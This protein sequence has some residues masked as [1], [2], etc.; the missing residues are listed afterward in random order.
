VNEKIE[1]RIEPGG[2]GVAAHAH[3][4][5]WATFEVVTGTLGARVGGRRT[6]L[7]PGQMLG[8]APHVSHSWWN[9]GDDELVVRCEIGSAI[10]PAS[11]ARV[12]E[13]HAFEPL[14]LQAA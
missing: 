12:V 5:Q 13:T 1:V 9:A 14:A 8:V 3:P 6:R 2:S 7:G 10:E 11:K 4:L